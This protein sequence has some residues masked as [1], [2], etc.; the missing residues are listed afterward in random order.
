MSTHLIKLK[1]LTKISNSKIQ[2]IREGT[3]YNFKSEDI[4]HL[5]KKVIKCDT[6]KEKIYA[7]DQF[8]MD[9]KLM[10]NK[11]QVMIKRKNE[12]HIPSIG[13]YTEQLLMLNTWDPKSINL[14]NELWEISYKNEL[15]NHPAF[16]DDSQWVFTCNIDDFLGKYD[17]E[18]IGNVLKKWKNIG[19]GY[20]FN[21]L[22]TTVK[23]F[24]EYNVTD[25]SSTGK[26]LTEKRNNWAEWF[27]S[28]V[29]EIN[30]DLKIIKSNAKTQDKINNNIPLQI[31][32]PPFNFNKVFPFD[33]FSPQILSNMHTVAGTIIGGREWIRNDG[34]C[35]SKHPIAI[36]L[37]NNPTI[38]ADGHSGGS[39][40]YTLNILKRIYNVGWIEWIK[41][42]YE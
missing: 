33:N 36:Q 1:N 31:L 25:F 16:R 38:N 6:I 8:N 27:N 3:E 24:S 2:K 17:N 7:I 28:N 18:K 42:K 41:Q 30:N 9:K 34:Y 40:S 20:N 39:M 26:I 10:P 23:T 14:V 15:L 22:L 11:K 13:N 32:F 21:P 19:T 4:Y 29:K 12:S 37:L 5:N 35:Y